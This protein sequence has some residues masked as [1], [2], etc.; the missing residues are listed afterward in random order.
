M[1][2][3]CIELATSIVAGHL[4]DSVWRHFLEGTPG[5]NGAA[6][7]DTCRF[8]LTLLKSVKKLA[9]RTAYPSPAARD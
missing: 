4:N 1:T 7:I 9:L 8:L 3:A 2:V 5:T 6:D